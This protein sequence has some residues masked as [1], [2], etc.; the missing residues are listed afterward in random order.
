M[1]RN[2]PFFAAKLITGSLVFISVPLSRGAA[3][4]AAEPYSVGQKVEVREGDSW[5][6][7]SVTGQEGRKFHVH[8]DGGD[9]SADEWV[10]PDRIRKPGTA[11]GPATPSTPGTPPVT[12]TTPAKPKPAANAA[13]AIGDKIETKWGGLWRKS[14]VVRKHDDWTLVEYEGSTYEWVQPWRLR[15]LGSKE[16]E[17]KYATPRIFDRKNTQPPKEV[18]DGPKEAPVADPPAPTEPG[19]KHNRPSRDNVDSSDA[20]AGAGT[21]SDTEGPNGIPIT[22]ADL[23]GG[24]D[25]EPTKVEMPATADPVPLAPAPKMIGLSHG[26]PAL[27]TRT[28]LL[29]NPQG[30]F[31]LLSFTPT[32]GYLTLSI[33]RIDLAREDADKVVPLSPNLRAMAISADGKRLVTRSSSAAQGGNWRLDLWNIDSEKP[34]PLLSFRAYDPDTG[35]SDTVIWANFVDATHLI[36]CSSAHAIT[37]WLL[38]DTSVK[39][40]YMLQGDESL[41]PHVSPGGKYL[42]VGFGNQLTICDALTGKCVLKAAAAEAKS[43][44]S[45]VRGDLKRLAMVGNQRLIIS[46]LE[47]DK[48]DTDV[49]IAGCAG[50]SISWIGNNLLLIDDRYLYDTDHRAVVWEY[51]SAGWPIASLVGTKLWFMAANGTA[52]GKGPG[53]SLLTSVTVPDPKVASADQHTED[54]AFAVQPGSR[55][56]LEVNVNGSADDRQKVIDRLTRQLQA[57]GVTV[58][59]GLPVKLVA[60]TKA[61][62]THSQTYRSMGFGGDGH[63]ETVTSTSTIFSLSFVVDSKPVWTTSSQTGGILP[64]F[65][66]HK[67]DQSIGDAVGQDNQNSVEWFLHVPFPRTI[68]KPR[69]PLGSSPLGAVSGRS[70][71]G[72]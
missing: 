14:A 40:V 44:A 51:T 13:F 31:A 46:D 20:P 9:T 42:I 54:A 53:R 19:T 69:D 67:K 29:V 24:V 34:K 28:E 3:P 2:R 65:V 39:E 63:T 45:S 23:V 8:Y 72:R 17:S 18:P 49:G 41:W 64:M 59:D 30:K 27:G 11:A 15:K 47:H 5:S 22:K 4:A 7:A 35:G 38:S 36:T 12:V 50:S 37:L 52:V 60:E 26:I 55:I 1:A 70:R 71:N 6:P 10:L 58:A 62:E 57:N 16:D 48:I 66:Y 68:L 21:I 43:M 33:Q 61:G 25:V 56:S 32:S